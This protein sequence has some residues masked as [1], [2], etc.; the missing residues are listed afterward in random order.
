MRAPEVF[1]PDAGREPLPPLVAPALALPEDGVLLKL[2]PD[3]AGRLGPVKLTWA[4][5][6]GAERYEVEVLQD[7]EGS[8]VF[9]QAVSTVE[10]KL[11]VLPAGRYR[12]TV[13]AVG[14]AGRSEPGPAR[15]FEL[16]SE[17]LKLEVQKGQ[18][19]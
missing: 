1:G 18:W 16:A 3:R 14:P 7:I 6:P 8:P 11:P 10:V 9:N 4:G 13:R 5:V 12:W 15:R 17:R 2:R 19:Q